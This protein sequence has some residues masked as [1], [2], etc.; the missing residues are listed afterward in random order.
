MEG[1]MRDRWWLHG[2][3]FGL[4]A[5]VTVVLAA[6]PRPATAQA[7]YPNKPIRV[8]VGFSPGGPSDTISRVIGA[9]MGEILGQQVIV[10]NRTGA[11]GQI[12]TEFVARS[13]PDGYTLL[14]TTTA[15]AVNET[16]AK[17]LTV[18]LGPDLVAVTPHAQ[19]ANVLVVHESLGPKNLKD[20][21]AL[22]K[23]KPGEIFY[24]TAGRGSATHLT[25]ELFN[26]MA[27]TKLMPVHY[28]GGGD[29]I[30]DL[31]SGQVKVMFS[32]IAPVINLIKER[33]LVGIATTGSKR[34][35][36]MP[37]LPTVAEA[38]VPGFET[39]LWIGLSA[40]AGTPKAILDKLARANAQAVA[41]PDVKDALAKLGFEPRVST[42]EQ[43]DAFYRAER[44]QWAKVIK[45]TGMDKE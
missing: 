6:V 12:A 31:L 19:T 41:A 33:K 1:M 14:N 43:F 5:A 29:T 8:I 18:K 25:S 42:P 34:E 24:A 28:R 27:G 22:A 16:L 4:V 15:N 2:L 10:E 9:K 20:F 13:E 21:I 39:Y 32:S 7:D 30:K 44:D 3:R 23:G 36:S 11:G 37:E 17:T 40:R 26:M 35:P 38:G 45:E